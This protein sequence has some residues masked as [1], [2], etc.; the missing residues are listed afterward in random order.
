MGTNVCG[1]HGGLIPGVQAAAATRIQM[2]VDD[3]VKRLHGMLDDPN[4]EPRDKVKILHDLLDR[5]GLGATSKHI[6]GVVTDDPVEALF[7]SIAADPNGTYDP[8]EASMLDP[9]PEML[10]LNAGADPQEAEDDDVVDAEIVEPEARPARSRLPRE[11][12]LTPE[13]IRKAIEKY[14]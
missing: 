7:R 5:G 4:V 10:A 2:S 6:V 3:A 8:R 13:H 1:S 14:V 9:D 12:P 11:K